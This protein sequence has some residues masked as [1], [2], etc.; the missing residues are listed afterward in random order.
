VPSF[1]SRATALCSSGKGFAWIMRPLSNS[2]FRAAG[3][4]RSCASTRGHGDGY[5]IFIRS[6]K[7]SVKHDAA[8][9]G[10]ARRT[11]RALRTHPVERRVLEGRM[12]EA[13]GAL[14]VKDGWI[15]PADLKTMAAAMPDC[16]LITVRYRTLCISNCPRSMSATSAPG[17]EA[18]RVRN[19]LS[20]RTR[21][22]VRSTGPDPA[23]RSA[24]GFGRGSRGY[25]C[26]EDRTAPVTQFRA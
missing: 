3:E 20:I 11:R 21:D 25:P 19:E 23:A 13:P 4:N 22:R 17:S 12:V 5:G 14:G 7:S 26:R 2:I 6:T 8:V 15:S 1:D 16:R 18:R 9:S 24:A 10:G